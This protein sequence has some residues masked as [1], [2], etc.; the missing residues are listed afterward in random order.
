MDGGSLQYLEDKY[1]ICVEEGI[2]DINTVIRT[3]LAQADRVLV[4]RNCS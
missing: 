4:F 3:L 1:R 2:H